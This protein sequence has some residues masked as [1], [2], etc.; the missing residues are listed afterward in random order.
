MDK[1]MH[2]SACAYVQ[3]HYDLYLPTNT[4]CKKTYYSNSRV[5]RVNY[6]HAFCLFV[7]LFV[8]CDA[9]RPSQQLWSCRDGQFTYPH[10]S[11]DMSGRCPTSKEYT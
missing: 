11:I 10:F 8:W 6:R 5:Q 1:Q 4:L 9:L 2:R 7:C 3:A